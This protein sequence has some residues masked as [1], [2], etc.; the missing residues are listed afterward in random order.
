MNDPR[1]SFV[2]LHGLLCDADTWADSIEVPE[3]CLSAITG[4]LARQDQATR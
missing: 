4:W 2:L 1:P 3:V